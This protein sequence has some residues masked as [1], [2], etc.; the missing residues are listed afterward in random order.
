MDIGIL[1][2]NM[3]VCAFMIVFFYFY[4][5]G[6]LVVAI[7]STHSLFVCFSI[8]CCYSDEDHC[9]PW[10]CRLVAMKIT[11]GMILL[12][13]FLQ[14]PLAIR[15]LDHWHDKLSLSH[16]DGLSEQH[17]SSSQSSL[18]HWS[19]QHHEEEGSSIVP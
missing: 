1:L 10:L 16:D 7:R 14:A 5:V 17:P 6:W 12:T 2:S 8:F 19:A 11:S 3:F 4:L 9:F 13:F 15:L 18:T